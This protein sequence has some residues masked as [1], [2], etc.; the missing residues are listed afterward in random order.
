M[1]WRSD[2]DTE[3]TDPIPKFEVDPDVEL[4]PMV[5][6]RSTGESGSESDTTSKPQNTGLIIGKVETDSLQADEMQ[7][8]KEEIMLKSLKRKQQAEENRLRKEE[9]MRL[10]KEAEA[11]KEEEKLRKKEEEK[12]R[13]EA[14]L[15]QHRLKKEMER[16][17]N[18]NV[19]D[20]SSFFL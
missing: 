10:K 4:E 16:L 8:R 14:I 19:G 18:Q 1:D 17:E 12:A 11:F 15:E 5:P 9:D 20:Y 6:L 13:R 7:R 2:N 3:S